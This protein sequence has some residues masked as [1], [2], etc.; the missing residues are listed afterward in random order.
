MVWAMSPCIAYW[1]SQRT[2]PARREL[3][4]EISASPVWWPA[5]PGG[6]ST[7]V[8]AEDNW[9]PPDNFRKTPDP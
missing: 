3:V 4:G 7:F 8:G 5:A 2:A 6:S 1:V 9:L